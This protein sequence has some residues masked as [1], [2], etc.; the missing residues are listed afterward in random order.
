MS[1]VGAEGRAS[2]RLRL[3]VIALALFSLAVA[4]TFGFLFR[5][6]TD[7]A[8]LEADEVEYY[9]MASRL[10]DGTLT[11][12]ARRTLGFPLFLAA[13]RLLGGGML[14]PQIVATCLFALAPPILFLLVRKVSGSDLS[15]LLAGIVLATWPPSLYYGTSL[16]SESIALPLFLGSLLLLPVG[17]RPGDWKRAILAGALLGCTT[18]V[19]P[20]YLLFL[21]FLVAILL[22]EDLPP[23]RILARLS[24]A[25]LGFALV[26]LPW[27][28]TLSTRFGHVIPVSANGG[29]TLA[30]SLNPTLAGTAPVFRE[31]GGRTFWTG[32][33]KWIPIGETGYLSPEEARL[34]YDRVDALLRERSWQ[35]I[36]THPRDAIHIELCK[37]GYLWGVYGITLNGRMQILTGNVPTILLLAAGLLAFLAWPG[38]RRPCVRLWILPIFVSGVALI[39]WGSW[40]FRHPADAGLIGFVAAALPFLLARLRARQSPEAGKAR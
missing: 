37:L 35:W 21:P 24:A 6:R 39:S 14:T 26:I 10:L 23:K 4:L 34:P 2:R 38:G 33:G 27:S 17:E 28:I 13:A 32:P 18:H 36:R 25:L 19:R 7:L 1:D 16:Y 8:L 11:L 40:R 3:Q 30:G 20:M 12:D 29:E 9:D 22:V 15:G 5:Y 31:G